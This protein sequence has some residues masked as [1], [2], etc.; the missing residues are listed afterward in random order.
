[1]RQVNKS[2]H[3]FVFKAYQPLTGYLKPE[4]I[5]FFLDCKRF[6]AIIACSIY[7]GSNN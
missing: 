2:V 3:G 4:D 7:T 6:L 1:M 5:Y